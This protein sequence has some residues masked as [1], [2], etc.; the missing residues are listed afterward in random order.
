MSKSPSSKRRRD[1][2]VL[3]RT[4]LGGNLVGGVGF[5][6]IPIIL[7][8]LI[9]CIQEFISNIVS[10]SV[11]VKGGE[12]QKDTN[13]DTPVSL[14][15]SD[16]SWIVKNLGRGM[17]EDSAWFYPLLLALF[18]GVYLLKY[19]AVRAVGRHG[20]EDRHEQ[21]VIVW[22]NILAVCTSAVSLNYA[23]IVV[24][25]LFW[26]GEDLGHVVA[27]SLAE[28]WTVVLGFG[29][30]LFVPG[31]STRKLLRRNKKE[32][33]LSLERLKTFEPWSSLPGTKKAAWV[34]GIWIFFPI[35][36][37]LLAVVS[38]SANPTESL[39]WHVGLVGLLAILPI[40]LALFVGASRAWRKW[41]DP[42]GKISGIL[43]VFGYVLWAL[44]MLG[45][46]I[47]FLNRGVLGF[48]VTAAIVLICFLVVAGWNLPRNSDDAR[49]HI[50][51]YAPALSM[52]SIARWSTL[53]YLERLDIVKKRLKKRLSREL[54]ARAYR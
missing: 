37:T 40:D 49:F 29:I 31:E 30:G 43:L 25:W 17:S 41:S 23:M 46:A 12:H 54:K 42:P 44:F 13:I 24:F 26:C 51:S 53:R 2:T 10:F 18:A 50:F 33:S 48:V 39:G 35:F 8:W 6:L 34:L 36:I 52:I 20:T 16:Y 32:R 3:D 1:W 38:V 4:G 22:A 14:F 5:T 11:Y 27:V 15:I 9:F 7:L 28:I 47:S 45:I 21:T 19:G